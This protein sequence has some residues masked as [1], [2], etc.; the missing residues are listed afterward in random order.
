MF[1]SEIDINGFWPEHSSDLLKRDREFMQTR[2]QLALINIFIAKEIPTLS[3][4]TTR[5]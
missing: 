2:N 5:Q 3:I 4:H 1:H